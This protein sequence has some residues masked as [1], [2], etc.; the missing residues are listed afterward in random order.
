MTDLSQRNRAAFQEHFP[1]VLAELERI[2]DPGS[3][4]VTNEGQPE[5]IDLGDVPLY[6]KPAPQW[7]SEQLDDFATDPDRLAFADPSHCNLSPVSKKLLLEITEYFQKNHREGVEN[8]PV[9]DIGFGFVFGIGLGLHIP[10]LV[11]KG[12]CRQLVLIEPMPE[13]ILHSFSAIDWGEIFKKA[14]DREMDIHFLVGLDPQTAV[15]EI[16][17][18]VTTKGQTFLDGSFAY[19][20]YVSWPIRETRTI[21][22]ERLKTYYISRGFF[23]DEVLMVKNTYENFNAWSS[24]TISLEGYI[25]QNMPVFIVGSG[26]SLDKD[27]PFLKQWRD[28]AIIYSCGT[29][30]G[31][32]LKNGI[33]PDLHVENENTPQLVNNLKEFADQYGLQDITLLASTTVNPEIAGMFDRRWFYFRSHLSPSLF[34]NGLV[35]PLVGAAPLVSNAAFTT[36]AILGFRNIYFFGV[37]CGRKKGGEHHSADAVY[38]E[39][40]YDNYLEGESLDLID[41][42]FDREVPGNF[43]GTVLSAWHLDMSRVGISGMQRLCNVNLYN[44][45]DGAR[46]DGAQPKAAASIRLDD[47]EGRQMQ[48][49]DRIKTQLPAYEPGA[50]LEPINFTGHV[51]AIDAFVERLNAEMDEALRDD[52]GFWAFEQRVL[53]FQ[54]KNFAECLAVLTIIGGTFTSMIRLGAFGGNRIKDKDARV[55]FLRFFIGKY[56]EACL[57]MAAEIRKLLSEMAS[58]VPKLTHVGKIDVD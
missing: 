22:N 43:G 44:C 3:R 26:A 8:Y 13:F 41:N 15:I 16:E 32:L 25:E 40:D 35:K 51:E 34:M 57:W 5:N 49:L 2:G 27:M 47:L 39:D 42:E 55:V 28:R 19:V 37:D 56:R 18:L 6:A 54:R 12:E 14:I 10:E 11:E 21:L 52:E 33:R 30:L 46:I 24:R 53:G 17:R 31:I 36:S 4:L 38:Y 7:T 58:G 23:E 20:H 48:I 45:S 29:S 50:F 1:A 9:T